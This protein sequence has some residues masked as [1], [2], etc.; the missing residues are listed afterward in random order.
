MMNKRSYFCFESINIY[1]KKM[2]G[3]K[4]GWHTICISGFRSERYGVIEFDKEHHV[5][6]IVESLSTLKRT[7]LFLSSTFMTIGSVR[8]LQR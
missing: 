7:L 2:C 5:T 8:L 6:N 3:F 1:T 4:K